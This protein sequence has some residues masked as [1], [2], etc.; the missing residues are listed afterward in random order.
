M[1]KRTRPSRLLSSADT[2]RWV[3]FKTPTKVLS[4]IFNL[5]LMASRS[6]KNSQL[7]RLSILSLFPKTARSSFGTH[8]TLIRKKSEKDFQ[9]ERNSLGDH[10]S[11][12]FN[13]KDPPNLWTLESAASF[14]TLTKL[15]Q[16]SM[17]VQMKVILFLSTGRYLKLPK[18]V[19]KLKNKKPKV[20]SFVKLMKVSVTTA[21]F[22]LLNAP[23]SMT[24]CSWPFTISTSVS[25]RLPSKTI[26]SPSSGPPTPLVLTTPAEPSPQQGQALF[27]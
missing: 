22:W 7:R 23:H 8:V 19:N 24:T 18:V 17:P 21:Q 3:T 16:L 25:G 15:P 20:S 6:T 9:W 13:C 1:K 14:S 10:S 12:P 26:M 4:L 2:S 11:P 5:F 27:I